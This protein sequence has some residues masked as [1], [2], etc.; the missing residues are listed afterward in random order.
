MNHGT[1]DLLAL[2]DAAIV[3]LAAR[4][5]AYRAA[6]ANALHALAELPEIAKG[7]RHWSGAIGA[8]SSAESEKFLAA[9]DAFLFSAAYEFNLA[10]TAERQRAAAPISKQPTT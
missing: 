8:E 6:V 3:S 10:A 5:Q 9:Q 7:I 2:K 1:P 4:R